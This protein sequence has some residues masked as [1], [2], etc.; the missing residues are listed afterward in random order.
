M[1]KINLIFHLLICKTCSTFS[2]KNA[3]LTTL[4]DKVHLHCIPEKE[5][6]KMKKEIVDKI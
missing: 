5:K 4:C 3:K 2:K 1:E 6:E